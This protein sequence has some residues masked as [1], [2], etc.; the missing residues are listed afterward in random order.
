MSSSA[1]IASSISLRSSMS[2]SVSPLSR[3][4]GDGHDQPIEELA[5]PM[6]QVEVPVRNRIERSGIDGDD[7]L[8]ET[9]EG[10]S[11]PMIL[12]WLAAVARQL[13]PGQEKGSAAM[14]SDECPCTAGTDCLLPSCRP[15]GR[16][17]WARLRHWPPLLA[18]CRSTEVSPS[19]LRTSV[20][21]FARDVHVLLQE[22]LGVLAALAD[23]FA[24]VAE[25]RARLLHQVSS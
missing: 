25:P 19:A 3:I 23:A 5:A 12:F 9:S 20:S 2:N 16:R 15:L 6:D 8:Q 10:G 21:I 4:A 11:L 17:E 24:L 7:L 22:L 18:P 14:S 13:R 1:V